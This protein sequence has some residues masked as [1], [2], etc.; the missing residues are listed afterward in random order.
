[1]RLLT[2]Y[3]SEHEAG[4]EVLLQEGVDDQNGYH[5]KEQLRR[6][7]MGSRPRTDPKTDPHKDDT[8]AGMG[9]STRE[10][11]HLQRRRNG[12][13]DMP[14]VTQQPS[15]ELVDLRE[16]CPDVLVDLVY[17]RPDNVFGRP[18]YQCRHAWL[19]EA[20]AGK[21]AQAAA[22]ART[23]GLRLLVLDAY[24]PLAVQ[25]MMWELLPDESFVAPPSRGSI[26]NRGA[27]VDVRLT[28]MAGAPLPMPSEYDEFSP[29]ASHRW[30]GAAPEL[31][32]RRELLRAI[33]ERA[34]FAA[35]HAE[36]WHYTDPDS[37]ACPLLDVSPCDHGDSGA[38]NAGPA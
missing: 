14:R 11:R 1:M 17:S 29:R 23:Y 3:A 6:A 2:L 26:H 28:D 19:L 27:A 33:M 30:T 5:P 16:V 34:G 36:W 37:A 24:R 38:R 22:D 35:Y 13:T 4:G 21:L 7:A 32:A 31:A 12:G 8:V 9:N 10:S 20:T 25:R 18:L 15:C